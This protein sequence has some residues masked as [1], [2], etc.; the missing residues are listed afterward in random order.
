MNLLS[1]H[2][3]AKKFTI[4]LNLKTKN[5]EGKME[6]RLMITFFHLFIQLYLN[7]TPLVDSG[8]QNT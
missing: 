1:L 6:I 2:N 7:V 3:I 5:Q 8:L 4:S